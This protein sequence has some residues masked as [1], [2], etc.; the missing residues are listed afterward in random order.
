MNIYWGVVSSHAA[1]STVH[2]VA[3]N[4]MLFDYI[5]QQVQIPH[6]WGRYIAGKTPQDLLTPDEVNFI[7]SSSSGSC[8]ILL[9]FYGATP[10]GDHQ[11]GVTD[12]L[13]AIE[14]AQALG[15]PTGVS[16]YGDIETN[17]PTSSDWLFGWW[18]TMSTSMFA[19]PGGFYCNPSA[20]NASNFSTP[21]CTAITSLAN[22]NPDG[23][24]RFNP[25]LFSSAPQLGCTFNRSSF[26]PCEPACVPDSVG[27]W[28]Y[29]GGC[30]KDNTSPRGLCDMDLANESGYATMWSFQG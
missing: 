3:G 25:P 20:R 13:N 19:N 5:T 2:N 14:A 22:L 7:S 8:R 27:I 29:A 11:T 12:A 1:N 30:F 24:L 21:Y 10:G 4:P 16:L 17:V 9:I 6:F 23:T 26:G 28:Q 15:V 18:E